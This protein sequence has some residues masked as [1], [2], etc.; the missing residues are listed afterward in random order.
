MFCLGF[1]C[2]GSSNGT[3]GN[4]SSPNYP[5]FYPNTVE[6]IWKINASEGSK[7][8]LNFTDFELETYNNTDCL[9]DYL[10]VSESACG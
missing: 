7:I 4:F 8:A 2:G 1:S 5:S 6:C 9:T 10:E 3:E